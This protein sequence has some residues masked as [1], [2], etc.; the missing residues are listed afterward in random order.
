MIGLLRSARDARAV[1]K[2]L[3]QSQAMIEFDLSGKILR[4]NKLF[5]DAMGYSLSEIVGRHH[6]M[7]VD[8]AYRA[9]PAY[10]QFWDALKRGEHQTAEFKRLGK[11]GREVWLQASYNPIIGTG[12]RPYK[13]LKIATDISSRKLQSA[14]FEGQVNAIAKSQAIIEFKMDGTVITANDKFLAALGYTLP[15]IQGKHHSMFVEPALRDSEQYR[16]FWENLRR[17][18]YQAAE[19]KRLGKGGKEVW[20][21]ASYNPILDPDGRPFKVVKFATDITVQVQDRMRARRSDSRWMPVSM[22]SRRR[23][24]PRPS[25]RRVRPAH[26]CRLPRMCRRWRPAQKS[27]CPR[28]GRSAARSP[29]PRVSPPKQWTKPRGLAL[30]LRNWPTR[31]GGSVRW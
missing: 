11:G 29:R 23:S 5:L 22:A 21:Q 25:R 2:A 9:S 10:A 13:V 12:G 30:L 20:I 18:Q 7:F 17:G 3:D 6:S 24:P 16:S 19:Y 28:W 14:D 8:D 1:I 4:A 27:W 31:P 15:E 26:R